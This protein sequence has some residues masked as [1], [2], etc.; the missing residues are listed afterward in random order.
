MSILFKENPALYGAVMMHGAA[1][2][3]RLRTIS[4]V[5]LSNIMSE[6]NTINMGT[7]LHLAGSEPQFIVPSWT[8][9]KLAGAQVLALMVFSLW[10]ACGE[11]EEQARPLLQAWP[12]REAV[13]LAGGTVQL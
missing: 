11:R 4:P 2:L 3:P 8:T 13:M 12:I 6:T 9:E 10:V 7:P 5:E 1:V